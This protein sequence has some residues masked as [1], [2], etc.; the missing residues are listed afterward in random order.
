MLLNNYN[1]TKK[2]LMK[3]YLRLNVKD[4]NCIV[5]VDGGEFFDEKLLLS[6]RL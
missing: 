1:N 4:D 2:N 3:I 6:I 5:G